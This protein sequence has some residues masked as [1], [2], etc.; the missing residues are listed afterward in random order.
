M[1]YKWILKK[2]AGWVA[3]YPRTALGIVIGYVVLSVFEVIPVVEIL[4]DFIVILGYVLIRRYIA[5]KQSAGES[6]ES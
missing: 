2:V 6:L 3:R 4:S 5:K 1:I